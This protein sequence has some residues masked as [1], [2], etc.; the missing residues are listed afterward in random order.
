M[1]ACT[2]FSC[3]PRDLYISLFVLL[4]FI[5][6]CILTK[7][8]LKLADTRSKCCLK[9]QSAYVHTCQTS[10][11]KSGVT[12][13]H[14]ENFSDFLHFFHIVWLDICIIKLT[15]PNNSVVLQ[16][17]ERNANIF[18]KNLFNNIYLH[19]QDRYVDNYTPPW[20][21]TTLWLSK[22]NAIKWD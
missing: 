16:D 17:V 14:L 4:E 19:G 9:Y 7:F 20:M 11:K 13:S 18:R 5:S 3:P 2:A 8:S 6:C 12:F 10:L 15:V 1:L 21:L 22:M